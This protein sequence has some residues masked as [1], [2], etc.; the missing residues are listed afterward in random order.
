M[1]MLNNIVAVMNKEE[2]RHF[3]LWLNSTNASEARKDVALFDFI[4]KSGDKY[5]EGLIFQ[6]LYGGKGKNS[7]YKLKH[8]LQ[9]DIGCN[10]ALLHFEKHETN[11]L[12]LFLSLYN[13]F[14]SRNETKLA[15]YYLKKAEK[16]ALQTEN[17]E[18]LDIVYANFVRLSNDLTEINPETYIQRRKENAVKL[19]KIRETDQVL[20]A[21]NYRLKLSQNYG[22]RDVGLLK[23]LDNTIKEFA[24]DDSIGHS[25]IFQTRI[26]RA[27]SQ[28]LI[29]NHNF[30]ELEKFVLL[31][32]GKF[33]AE[34]WFDKT[35]HE[36][37]I[38]MLIYIINATFKNRKFR[39]SLDYAETLGEELS[40][41]NNLFYD[42]YLFFY[43][44]ALVINYAQSDLGRGLKALDEAE[45]EM[46]TK[47]N[48][49]YDFF[50]CWN[51]ATLLFYQG[52]YNEAIRN[53]TRLYVNDHFKKA[54]VSLKIKIA[55]A[56]CIM[57]YESR[58]E[59]TSLKRVE[60]VRKQFSSQLSSD[61]FKRERFVLKLFPELIASDPME[62]DKKLWKEVKRFVLSP[63]KD[64]VEDGEVLRYRVWLAP[65]VGIETEVLSG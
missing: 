12:F 38:Q 55:V 2:V 53:L 4:R 63:V 14:T 26:F 52:K 51:K 57:Q 49:Y 1:E 42:K 33:R 58:D 16:R 8:R 54:D 6:K 41:Y 60:Q 21:V 56:E 11:N 48:S 47:K 62:K 50:I 34:K 19:N 15:L 28:T 3:K 20:A 61:D 45:R 27:V 39:E 65:K 10:L 44:N 36:T 18:V 32:Y 46:K 35:N 40:A 7:F 37:K 64:S 43:Y 59:E 24:Q 22:K 5:D 25:K 31:M 13:I 23:L 29:Q 30:K 9:E 17:L